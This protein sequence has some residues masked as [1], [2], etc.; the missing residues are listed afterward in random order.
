MKKFQL[1]ILFL[2]SIVLLQG[3]EAKESNG[4][5]TCN[6]FLIME[7]NN[8]VIIKKETLI[9]AEY[10]IFK[11]DKILSYVM[12]FPPGS[13]SGEILQKSQRIGGILAMF[14][15]NSIKVS[16]IQKYGSQK[17]MTSIDLKKA[18]N[19]D[20]RVNVTGAE[21]YEE[22]FIVE[23]FETVKDDDGP[24]MDIFAGQVS[25]YRGDYSF[26]VECLEARG[27]N[28][29]EGCTPYKLH[30]GWITVDCE[31]SAAIKGRFVVDLGAANT[32][33]PK[34]ML[35]DGNEILQ[36][37]MVEHSSKGV[38]ISKAVSEGASGKVENIAGVSVIKD[39]RI[40]DITLN[41]FK[42]TVLESFPKPFID[43]GVDGV[44]GRDV[45]MKTEYLEFENLKGEDKHKKM[46]LTK[47]DKALANNQ[48]EIPFNIAEGGNIYF[49]GR[50]GGQPVHF[51]FDS[52][53]GNS[54]INKKFLKNN[55]ISYIAS[56]ED[57][58]TAYGI[59]GKGTSYN[60]IE[61]GDIRI[62][63]LI[64]DKMTF[65]MSDENVLKSFGMKENTCLLGMDF[66]SHYSRL[67]FDFKNNTLLLWR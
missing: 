22:A 15:N 34:N 11:D 27:K 26:F 32:V 39:F 42:V 67:V 6:F 24:I 18:Q 46:K 4:K 58:T 43:A 63:D 55:E 59:D 64:I 47:D 21:G 5:Q 37:Q 66:L 1:I 31:L 2:C 49:D 65:D 25:L 45:L 48:Y 62:G 23:G 53:A 54:S 3:Q 9:E 40:G 33:I 17:E 41:N 44:L 61:L 29:I 28:I 50:I 16:I 35:P 30:R 57:K 19:I 7:E 38:E 10:R 60:E 52:G 51:F 13:K 12:V 8:K 14:S 36:L 56:N 20:I